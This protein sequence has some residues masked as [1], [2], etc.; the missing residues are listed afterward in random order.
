[1]TKI[2][3]A[4]HA[5]GIITT[6]PL[7]PCCRVYLSCLHLRRPG[8]I[9][10]V[11]PEAEDQIVVVDGPQQLAVCRVCHDWLV[12]LQ[13]RLALEQYLSGPPKS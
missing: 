3:H 1:M 13:F 12:E 10:V 6:E 9:G 4:D 7:V 5:Q 2:T 8:P 11:S